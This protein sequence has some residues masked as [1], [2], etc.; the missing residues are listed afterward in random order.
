MR[1]TSMKQIFFACSAVVLMLAQ[2]KLFWDGPN[3]KITND[4][5]ANKFLHRD[6]RSGW[7]L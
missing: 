2:K 7:G 4:E 3:M 1:A 5:A 6:Y